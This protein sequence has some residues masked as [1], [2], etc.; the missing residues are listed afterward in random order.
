MM[1][2]F[3]WMDTEEW[4]RLVLAVNALVCV[5]IVVRLMFYQ[6]KGRYRFMFSALAYL[7]ILS[8]GWIAVRIFYGQYSGADPA[9]LLLNL[10]FCV[11]IWGAGG[12]VA[13]LTSWREQPDDEGTDNER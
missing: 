13:K 7:I 5:L 12:N 9:E 6:K 11:A 2:L 3:C 1:N 4:Q 8:A 10:S